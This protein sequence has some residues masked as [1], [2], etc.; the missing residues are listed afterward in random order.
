MT[1]LFQHPFGLP[2][3][4]FWGNFAKAWYKASFGTFLFNSVAVTLIAVFVMILLGALAAHSLVRFRFKG[5]NAL[6][7]Y[8]L[9][10]QTI[11]AQLSAVPLL[12]LIRSLGLMSTRAGI[13]LVYC[14]AG[15]PFVIFL[16]VGFFKTLPADIFDAAWID[17]CSELGIFWLIVVPIA[18]AGLGTAAVFQSLWVWNDFFYALMFLRKK[19]V[20]TLTIGVFSIQGEYVT[21]YPVVFAALALSIIPILLLYSVMSAQFTKGITAGAVKG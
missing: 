10:G 18:K 7:Y 4:L 1:D 20:R 8:F 16:L 5:G 17:G 2:R 13:I 9:A 19:A 3:S 21:D 12:V 11:P 15:L 14:S 6:L